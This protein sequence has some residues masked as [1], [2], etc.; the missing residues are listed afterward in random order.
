[1]TNWPVYVPVIVLD[2]PAARSPSAQISACTGMHLWGSDV[3]IARCQTACLLLP[4]RQLSIRES[5][6]M[7]I[8]L[9][10]YIQFSFV[11]TIT[12]AV[13]AAHQQPSTQHC[14]RIRRAL[15]RGHTMVLPYFSLM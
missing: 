15:D 7:H 8:I 13:S 11:S 12:T 2:C 9:L 14:T 1:M 10:C 4:S 5:A 6:F 3:L